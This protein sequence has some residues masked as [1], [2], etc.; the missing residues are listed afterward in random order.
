[1]DW[2]L[3]VR[4]QHAGSWKLRSERLYPYASVYWILVL[5]NTLLRFCWT[6]SFVPIR[7]LS[8]AGVLTNI[9][10][11]DTW[12]SILA[13]TI[14]SAEIIRR[15][16]WG[17]LRVEWEAIKSRGDQRDQLHEEV[18]GS[19]EM[20]P[21]TMQ[22][23]KSSGAASPLKRFGSRELISDMSLMNSFQVVGELC[24]Y[25]TAFAILGLSI[26]AHRQTL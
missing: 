16:L 19:M 15:T 11:S 6:L 25:T 21:M 13:P 14:A 1:M 17:L 5:A 9:F 12:A 22:E 3:F 10:S 7:Y 4:D 2:G 8:D 23:D 18:Q 26:A 24:L 20:I